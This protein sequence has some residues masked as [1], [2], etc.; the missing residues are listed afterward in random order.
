MAGVVDVGGRSGGAGAWLDA[1]NG[2]VRVAARGRLMVPG[3]GDWMRL[4][5]HR[6]NR[7][8]SEEEARLIRAMNGESLPGREAAFR[9]Y[10]GSVRE[11]YMTANYAKGKKEA[12]AHD[13]LRLFDVVLRDAPAIP[14]EAFTGK[15]RGRYGMAY[16]RGLVRSGV[17]TGPD[18]LLLQEHGIPEHW[19]TIPDV[20]FKRRNRG[21]N[22]A[23]DRHLSES[24]RGRRYA[25]LGGVI[26]RGAYE[27]IMFDDDLG[28]RLS[29]WSGMEQAD[30]H[31]AKARSLIE[32][33][34]NGVT[35]AMREDALRQYCR[36]R[37]HAAPYELSGTRNERNPARPDDK[38]FL[39]DIATGRIPAIIEE[40][41]RPLPDGGRSSTIQA[42]VRQGIITRDEWGTLRRYGAL[43]IDPWSGTIQAPPR[44][45]SD[46]S[47]GTAA[48]RQ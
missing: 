37:L 33:M 35:L 45:E 18:K 43:A 13:L 42:L 22:K 24:E 44:Y 40:D 26:L 10:Y 21:P 32:S 2:R 4:Q 30:R 7:E 27:R 3:L 20:P 1:L 38:Q 6:M 41:A 36:C 9:A 28:T 5:A 25:R 47:A 12:N 46:R 23:G 17:L 14:A 29:R 34:N 31:D 8:P 48:A 16:F 15:R 11:D 39:I 19:L